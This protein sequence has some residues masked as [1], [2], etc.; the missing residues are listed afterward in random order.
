MKRL[1]ILLLALCL[2]V[3]AVAC[4][5]PGPESSGSQEDVS[6]EDESSA[7]PVTEESSEE[8]SIPECEKKAEI[9]ALYHG[10]VEKDLPRANALLGRPYGVNARVS[11]SYPDRGN[12]LSDGAVP[13]SFNK[14]S[15][16]GFET[17]TCR[18]D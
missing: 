1:F 17:G 13:E 9:D 10:E 5:A 8:I 16:I 11:S 15:W 6:V 7:G 14:Y 18:I 2:L 4:A 3:S 12:L